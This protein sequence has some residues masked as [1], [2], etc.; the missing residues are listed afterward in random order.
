M[1]YKAI[2]PTLRGAT[3]RHPT[4]PP[5]GSEP[6][7]AA[8]PR[9][10][11]ETFLGRWI[12]TILVFVLVPALL[13]PMLGVG[14]ASGSDYLIIDRAALMSLPTSGSAWAAVDRAAGSSWAA[15]NLCDQNNKTDALAL[16]A[17][18]VYARTGE[19]SY[20]AKVRDAI[21][22]MM[23]TQQDGCS[24]AVLALGRQLGGWVLAAD[25][26]D[27]RDLDPS[28]DATFRG[29]LSAIRTKDIGGQGRWYAL[30]QTSGDSANNWGTFA[31]ASRV[32]AD[33]YLA[34]T[35]DLATAWAIF[36]GYSDGS[37]P[38]NKTASWSSAW[39]CLPTLS[40]SVKRLPIAIDG[41]C[42]EAGYQ[43]DGLPVEDASRSAFPVPSSGYINEALQGITLSALLLSRAGYPAFSSGDRALLRVAQAVDRYGDLNATT[44]A[45]HTTWVIN[46]YYGTHLP[47]VAA[48]YGRAFGFTDWLYG[49]TPTA[50]PA[51]TRTPAPDPSPTASPTPT[52]VPTPD[53]TPTASPA[54]GPTDTPAPRSTA[55]PSPVETTTAAPTASATLA[56]D[57]VLAA[58]MADPDLS[59]SDKRQLID[60]YERLRG[61]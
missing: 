25:L 61:R 24:N 28:A 45:Q 30:D 35:Q 48:S 5:R 49:P 42:T 41:S 16:A 31:T 54:A 33:R 46:A 1:R 14:A 60:L 47:T 37:W 56:P 4:D 10:R 15:P 13:L 57:A 51:P 26:I 59:A 34:D 36:K 21:A 23:P 55:S 38:F 39:S 8:P 58:I 27:L 43:L 32:A 17:G 22:A 44:V 29:W 9:G 11:T 19:T 40:S 20:A 50:T 2:P 53:I 7:A 6:A 3:R 12:S 52:V 18:L